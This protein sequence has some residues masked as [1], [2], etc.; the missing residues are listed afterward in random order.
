MKYIMRSNRLRS[1][2]LF[3]SV[4]YAMYTLIDIY[5]NDL[6]VAK[7]VGPQEYAI[8][9]GILT[10]L[11]AISATFARLFHKKYRNRS[12][13]VMSMSYIIACLIIGVVALVF[14]N[15]ISIPIMIVMY[16]I[17]RMNVATWH[18]LK[19]K[20][21][22]NFTTEKSRTKIS[23]SFELTAG[24]VASV[25]LF[26]GSLLLHFVNIENSFILVS[27]VLLILIVLTLDYMRSRFG[28][29]PK[30]YKKEDINF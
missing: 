22:K 6:L 16:G 18:I 13:T 5:K 27:L 19:Q 8:I 25:F 28:L 11:A 17:L 30:Q 21:L 4:F 15:T 24:I 20:Y 14:N 23:F 26:I 3:G 1:Y 29:K 9:Y 12:L 10:L 2:I 7:G